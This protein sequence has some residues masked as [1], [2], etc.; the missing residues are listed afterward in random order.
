MCS[1]CWQLTLFGANFLLP[2]RTA[3]LQS[4]EETF[5]TTWISIL[6][7]LLVP[8]LANLETEGYQSSSLP[9]TPGDGLSTSYAPALF[10]S[11]SCTPGGVGWHLSFRV[12]TRC[13]SLSHRCRHQ[14]LDRNLNLHH[15]QLTEVMAHD[16]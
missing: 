9:F 14:A 10:Q 15:C 5:F 16:V 11:C 8:K 6:A 2:A 3:L 4:S 13:Y 12:K 7:Q 1:F